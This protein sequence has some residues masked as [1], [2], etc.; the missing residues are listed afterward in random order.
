MSPELELLRASH[1]KP[2]A[3]S[4][5]VERLDP[6]NGLL[7]AVNYDAAFDALLMTFDEGGGLILAPEFSPASATAA[8]I[9]P[10]G[11]LSNLLPHMQCA[12]L[13]EI[14]QAFGPGGGRGTAQAGRMRAIGLTL[15]PGRDRRNL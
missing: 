2:W 10:T 1:I 4:N 14:D 3:S 6:A 5:N 12:R 8:G 13:Q 9:N 15:R 11:K 7:L